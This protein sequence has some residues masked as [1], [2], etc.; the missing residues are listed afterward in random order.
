MDKSQTSRERGHVQD[1]LEA[2]LATAQAE[3]LSARMTQAYGAWI[4]CYQHYCTL[5]GLSWLEPECMY[6]FLHYLT[7]ERDVAEGDRS[8]AIDALM[9]LYVDV[10]HQ[11]VMGVSWEVIEAQRRTRDTHSL[12]TLAYQAAAIDGPQDA[13][14]MLAQ[15]L[16]HTPL[17]MVDAVR[18]RAGDV[19]LRTG[20]VYIRDEDGDTAYIIAVPPTLEAPL[21]RLIQRAIDRHGDQYV[22]ALLFPVEDSAEDEEDDLSPM[23]TLFPQ[24]ATDDH[25]TEEN[26]SGAKTLFYIGDGMPNDPDMDLSQ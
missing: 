5:R 13:K 24:S 21:K 4:M 26:A 19:N 10:L 22:H 20:H 23:H 25:E 11:E 16:F 17:R 7:E 3:G 18:L 6:S 12:A 14:G 9:F 15:L 2:V 8:R 1:L